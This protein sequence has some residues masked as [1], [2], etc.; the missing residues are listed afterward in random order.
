MVLRIRGLPPVTPLNAQL[1][2]AVARGNV[3][4]VEVLLRRGGDP[5]TE[6]L[7]G[8]T[9]LHVA[10]ENQSQ[11]IASVLL[12]AGASVNRQT[13]LVLF[14]PLMSAAVKGNVEIAELLLSRG[15]DPD[16]RSAVGATALMHAVIQRHPGVVEILLAHGARKDLVNNRGRTPLAMA[17]SR[18]YPELVELLRDG[19]N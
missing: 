17:R 14:T 16:L 5:N 6:L 18:Q 1:R 13:C 19:D 2:L 15:A 8:H 11:A 12:D 10:A 9:L 7:Y 4:N 3:N